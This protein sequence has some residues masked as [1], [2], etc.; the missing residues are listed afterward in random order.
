MTQNLNNT[1]Y[2]HKIPLIDK[3]RKQQIY[4]C[5]YNWNKIATRKCKNMDKDISARRRASVRRLGAPEVQPVT[6]AM[7]DK[8]IFQ[9][10]LKNLKY[11][12]SILRY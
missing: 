10:F 4:A 5:Y 7:Q 8:I 9:T 3:I 11:H 6:A 1:V 12:V 2:L